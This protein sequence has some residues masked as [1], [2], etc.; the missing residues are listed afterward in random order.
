MAMRPKVTSSVHQMEHGSELT[1]ENNNSV[2]CPAPLIPRV[3]FLDAAGLRD[4]TAQE[5]SSNEQ[6][7]EKSAI[8]LRGLP[9]SCWE[10]EVDA[11]RR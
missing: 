11:L 4:P 8:T 7:I 6:E 2:T 3:Q 9:V 10:F 5:L 1:Y